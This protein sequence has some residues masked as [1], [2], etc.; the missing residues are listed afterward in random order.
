MKII[1]IVNKVFRIIHKC[2]RS[3]VP[4]FPITCMSIFTKIYSMVFNH[5][6]HFFKC[7]NLLM[8]KVTTIVNYYIKIN[9]VFIKIVPK[10]II[11]LITNKNLNIVFFKLFTIRINIYTNDITV[12]FKVII[13]HIQTSSSSYTNF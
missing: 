12:I 2:Y 1:E 5:W 11:T 7:Y 9:P 4:L 8:H 13:P 6:V 10:C 3:I